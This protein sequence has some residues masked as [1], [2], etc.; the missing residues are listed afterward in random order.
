MSSPKQSSGGRRPAPAYR[1]ALLAVATAV[2]ALVAYWFVYPLESDVR[3]FTFS[4]PAH[5]AIRLGLMVECLRCLYLGLDGRSPS[6]VSSAAPGTTS[7]AILERVTV[8]L[9]GSFTGVVA[10]SALDTIPLGFLGLAGV[11]AVTAATIGAFHL[12]G[13]GL[14]F[15]SHR[16][17]RWGKSLLTFV[18]L[19]ALITLVI[20]VATTS[21]TSRTRK[22]VD[23]LVFGRLWE[24]F[25]PVAW[26]EHTFEIYAELQRTLPPTYLPFAVLAGAGLLYAALR[27]YDRRARGVQS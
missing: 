22:L 15:L 8:V 23:T 17:Q 9:V 10:I 18:V 2:S 26:V 14:R 11:T 24:Y 3:A 19:S 20:R 27:A 7:T 4:P 12:V 25:P 13:S 16:L 6:R 1:G 5:A 21:D